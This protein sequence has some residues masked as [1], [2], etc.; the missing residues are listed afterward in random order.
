MKPED[1]LDAR[2]SELFRSVEQPEPSSGFASRTMQAVRREPL[3]AG[4]QALRHPW[5]APLAWLT[6]VGSA[7]A[8]TYMIMGQPLAAEVFTSL[9]G[10][11]LRAGARSVHFV[12]A[13]LA[14][15]G[16]FGTIGEA[17]ARAA[18]TREGSMSLILTAAVAGMSLS[19][20]RRLLF[21]EGEEPQ[22]QELS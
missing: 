13:G 18:L 15:S 10:F 20:L 17:M 6:L 1:D 11:G 12:G 8:M 7:A 3:P 14:L 9:L 4:R 21:S 19:A 5:G 22:W 16:L 2:L